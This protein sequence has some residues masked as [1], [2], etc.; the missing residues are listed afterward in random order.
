M[1]IDNHFELKIVQCDDEDA[2]EFNI[3][4]TDVLSLLKVLHW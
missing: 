3:Y 1:P 2:L 4:G